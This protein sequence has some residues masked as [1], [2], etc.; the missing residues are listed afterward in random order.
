MFL[1]L[2]LNADILIL[3]KVNA[4]FQDVP[5]GR[6]PETDIKVRTVN[7]DSGP[8]LNMPVSQFFLVSL[9]SV[10]RKLFLKKDSLYCL[11]VLLQAPQKQTAYIFFFPLS[12]VSFW[13]QGHN[14]TAHPTPQ[15]H[16]HISKVFFTRKRRSTTAQN[17]WHV[18]GW[19]ACLCLFP[20]LWVRRA[21]ESVECV[22]TAAWKENPCVCVCVCIARKCHHTLHSWE[23]KTCTYDSHTVNVADGQVKYATNMVEAQW[24]SYTDFP[25]LVLTCHPEISLGFLVSSFVD[26]RDMNSPLLV[27]SHFLQFIPYLYLF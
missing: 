24:A 4:P 15:T 8:L 16:T 9:P 12:L 11:Y 3:R 19:L 7:S 1:T 13:A 17:G 10:S 6:R 21:G 2:S 14:N 25:K 5:V 26:M 23:D 18:A 22:M 27:M 20:S